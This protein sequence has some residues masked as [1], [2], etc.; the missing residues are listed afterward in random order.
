MS[1]D[2]KFTAL[3]VSKYWPLHP[4][5]GQNIQQPSLGFIHH[6]KISNKNKFFYLQL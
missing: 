3:E 2:S 4:N 5:A 1:L 6:L